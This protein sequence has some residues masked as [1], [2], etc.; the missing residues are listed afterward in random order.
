MEWAPDA[1][2]RLDALHRPALKPTKAMLAQ[3]KEEVASRHANG[4]LANIMKGFRKHPD[5]SQAA[6]VG[7]PSLVNPEMISA[8]DVVQKLAPS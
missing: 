7:D 6:K 5:T 8:K 2:L 4:T 1:K 3:N